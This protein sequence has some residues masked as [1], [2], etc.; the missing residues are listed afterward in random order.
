MRIIKHKN[1]YLLIALLLS[2]P[3]VAGVVMQFDLKVVTKTKQELLKNT[4]EVSLASVITLKLLKADQEGKWW[5]IKADNLRLNETYSDESYELPFAFRLDNK[6]MINHFWFPDDLSDAH[7]QKLKGLAYYFQW[8]DPVQDQDLTEQDNTG[9]YDA[10][11]MT[12]ESRLIIKDK[13][14]YQP[15]KDY[16]IKIIQ[17]HH[18]ILKAT[19]FFEYSA[20]IEKLLFEHDITMMNLIS[21][22]K[23][24]IKVRDSILPSTILDLPSDLSLW[25]IDNKKDTTNNNDIELQQSMLIMILANQD[26]TH[27]PSSELALQLSKYSEGLDAIQLMI[28]NDQI[29]ESSY[30]KLFNALGQIDNKSS[31]LLLSTLI[32]NKEIA[33]DVKFL[34]MR[35]LTKGQSALTLNTSNNILILLE[36]GVDSDDI[37]LR[38][39]IIHG[40]G[41][42]LGQRLSNQL[43]LDIKDALVAKMRSENSDIELSTLIS[44]IGN[45]KDPEYIVDL[46]EYKDSASSQVRSSLAETLGRIESDESHIIL[47]EMLTSEFNGSSIVQSS[48]LK[49]LK[50][51]PID[52][53][54]IKLT[55]S[56]IDKSANEGV[57]FDAIDLISKKKISKKNKNI[58][59]SLM[60]KETNKKNFTAIANLLHQ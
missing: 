59:N 55:L 60:T 32:I 46:Q 50:N 20:G 13:L 19:N 31:Q 14:S 42:I 58:L 16:Q 27:I 57:R 49:S 39:S 45:T 11:Y 24:E 51:Y 7:I 9:I 56:Y 17:S 30:L 10:K 5:G 21:K 15:A 38:S 48:I 34:S 2:F 41:T 43:S 35:A 52:D 4:T 23:Y 3:C 33:D 6:G 36:E 37:V 1:L 26:L 22:Q 40:I 12:S 28:T 47:T 25:H 44:S 29:D 8:Q 54:T 53:K 18:E